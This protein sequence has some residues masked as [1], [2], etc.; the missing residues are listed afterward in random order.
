MDFKV[1]PSKDCY[2]F[3]KRMISEILSERGSTLTHL[4]NICLICE[5]VFPTDMC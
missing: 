1:S 4:V 5:S 2:D 3:S